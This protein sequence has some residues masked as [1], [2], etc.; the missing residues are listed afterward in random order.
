MTAYQSFGNGKKQTFFLHC[1]YEWSAAHW[2][3]PLTEKFRIRVCISRTPMLKTLTPDR[4]PQ[5]EN[6]ANRLRKLISWSRVILLVSLR[7]GLPDIRSPLTQAPKAIKVWSVNYFYSFIL[8]QKHKKLFTPYNRITIY[9]LTLELFHLYVSQFQC[10]LDL[11]F[12]I[13]VPT[14]INTHKRKYCFDVA[15]QPGVIGSPCAIKTNKTFFWSV[16][17]WAVDMSYIFF[18]PGTV[19]NVNHSLL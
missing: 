3:I 2:L 19:W 6:M 14:I 16:G 11:D 8:F 1:L 18:L 15:R 5:L 12:S 17:K 9:E 4:T 7:C 13:I 10:Q